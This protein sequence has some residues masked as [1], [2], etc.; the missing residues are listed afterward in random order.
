[1]IEELFNTID[2][3]I[4]QR[5]RQLVAA[6]LIV[7][8]IFGVGVTQ[9]SSDS[10][11]SQFTQDIPSQEALEEI[12]EKFSDARSAT[13][14]GQTTLI[15]EKKN[16]L[17]KRSLVSMA[18]LEQKLHERD[19]LRVESSSSVAKQVALQIDRQARTPESRVTA[20]ETATQDDIQNAVQSSLSNQ[21]SR[22]IVS[23]DYN[24]EDGTASVTLTTVSHNV[25]GLDSGSVGTSSTTALQPIQLSIQSIT[26][27][28]TEGITVFGQGI[29]S[30]EL[31]SVTF[32]SLTLVLPFAL[33]FIL[34]FLGVA[35][36]DPI[37]VLLALA[38]LLITVIWTLGFMGFVGI[39]F[40]QL[41]VAVPPLLLAVG[42][43]FGI[44]AVNRYREELT[45]ERSR[46]Q[47]MKNA[48][49]QLLIAFG[50]VTGTTVIGFGSNIISPLPPIREFGIVAAIGIFFTFLVFGVFLP[51]TKILS[52]SI[53]E[54]TRIP[55]FTNKAL[56]SED[57]ALGSVLSVGVIASEK[58]PKLVVVT[59]LILGAVVG[60]YGT[61]ISG[62]F[63]QDVFL[64]PEE[65]PEYVDYF[66]GP[67]QPGEYDV[68]RVIN[69]IEENFETGGQTT[70]T[71]YV[72]GD[73]RKDTALEEIQRM[74]K[75]PPN[76]IVSSDNY[77]QQ[78]SILSI[79]NQSKQ[80]PAVSSVVKQNDI[81]GNG[82]AD[83]NIQ[84]VYKKTAANR[85]DNY[86]TDSRDATR[87]VYSIESDATNRE[88]QRVGS[89]IAAETRY[90]AIPTGPVIV[91]QAVSDLISDSTV[92][93][94]AIALLLTT[95]FLSIVYRRMEGLARLALVN[96]V[97]VFVTIA[98]VAGTMRYL[99]IPLN[100]LTATT[101]SIAIGLG[102]DYTT[103]MTH[104]I[105]DE[106]KT[107]P[108]REAIR[109][110]VQGTGGALFG[111]MITTVFGIGSLTLAITPLLGQFG[112]V[113]A[114]S[115]VY[116]FV[117]SVIMLPPLY[118]ILT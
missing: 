43:D 12:N 11:T 14:G 60:A 91:R 46:K 31:S 67:L 106:D 84:Q 49:D 87:V 92:R 78:Q 36:R 101:L 90:N 53:K 118:R 116:S 82:V 88:I 68:T 62:T 114:I 7:T 70:L 55:N 109:V 98:L 104:R 66:P 56:G 108:T 103:H 111:S 32:D 41:L 97:P 112:L 73:I 20:L 71:L 28:T 107:K 59:I 63:S 10:G 110:S 57:S 8:V 58:A 54:Q 30:S 9:I 52:D 93:S 6:F 72:Q 29:Q 99:N 15:Q 5:P 25:R 86:V 50:I 113:I 38:S 39:P 48:T 27:R 24:S 34:I 69:T 1:M 89:Q 117:V 13:G 79:I 96:V 47:S 42:I 17:S 37:D 22:Q 81:D 45:D 2:R 35:Y 33:S 76:I 19:G 83:D 44:H 75:N 64:P 23:K 102:V 100:A 61:G 3:T 80:D 26:Q 85:I 94:L 74:N 18:K 105:I 40:T 65:Q 51:A 77:A 21:Q 95:V 115:I 16:V 4:T